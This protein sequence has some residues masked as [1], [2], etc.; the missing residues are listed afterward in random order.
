M[1]YTEGFSE[2]ILE[3]LILEGTKWIGGDIN[4]KK[5]GYIGNV[6]KN[7][8]MYIKEMKSKYNKEY[9]HLNFDESIEQKEEEERKQK[10]NEELQKQEE[11]KQ[12]KIRQCEL[13]VFVQ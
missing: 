8:R 1:A 4:N 13:D 12:F 3:Y 6:T 9:E 11:E 5:T 7:I 2:E 10:E